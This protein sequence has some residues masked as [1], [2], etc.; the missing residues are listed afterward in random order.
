MKK[1]VFS[2]VM[3][4][5]LCLCCLLTSCNVNFGSSGRNSG[6]SK[7][8]VDQSSNNVNGGQNGGLGEEI[9]GD[10]WED[11]G[12]NRPG[13]SYPGYSYPGF[14]HPD[15]SYPSFSYPDFSYPDYS[16]PSFSYPDY[17]YPD[18]SE[19]EQ[20]NA[21]SGNNGSDDIPSTRVVIVYDTMYDDD[22]H[23]SVMVDR[24][25]TYDHHYIPERRGYS[26]Y[27]WYADKAM[28]VPANEDYRYTEDINF[29]YACWALETYSI[30]YENIDENDP[31]NPVSY[32]VWSAIELMA[33][34]ARE[35]YA[36][37]GWFLDEEL[38]EE[39]TVIENMVG[40][41]VLYAKW[42]EVAP[43]PNPPSGEETEPPVLT[44][45]SGMTL[46]I[47]AT[48]WVIDMGPSAPWAQVELTV[49]P[50]GWTDNSG[51]GFVI[52]NSVLRRAMDI[53]ENY[54][55]TLNWI[56]SRSNQIATLLAES[57][58][59]GNQNTSFHIAMP[60]MLELQRI[61]ST[62]SIYDLG[63]SRHIDL[64]KSY[65]NQAAREAYTV[66]DHT[67]F[68]AGDFSFLDEMTSRVIYYN[69]A[70]AEQIPAFPDIYQ[71]VREGEWTIDEMSNLSKLV[72]E[73]TGDESWGDE[74]VY[75][76]GAA[77][78]THL[79][80]TSG[81]RQVGI[82][83]FENGAQYT[84]TLNHPNISKLI[85]KLL[86]ISKSEWA[87][88]DWMGGYGAL[89][90]AFEEGRLLFYD[91]VLQK[92]DYFRS[93][94]E[95]FRVGVLPV[96]KLD[97]SQE[98]YCTPCSYQSVFMCIPKATDDREMSEY[99]VEILSYTGQKYIMQAYKENLKISFDPERAVESME[100]IENYIFP[101]IVYDVGKTS[102]WSGLLNDVEYEAYSQGKNNFT[103]AYSQ[104]FEEAQIVLSEWNFA[105]FDYM[106]D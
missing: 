48:V 94:T 18:Y 11:D 98:E 71:R 51:F 80:Q 52:N 100:M 93:Q 12:G 20:S 26:F 9:G 42:E 61:V 90:E 105:W 14:S 44:K 39:I 7:Y 97:D 104:A 15:Y 103:S 87:R 72:S 37:V 67:L 3:A 56:N 89:Q 22:E 50:D 55:V 1:R 64:G 32:D 23:R 84:V 77:S 38:T 83:E 70:M 101:N 40:A 8:S 62:N 19:S 5:L 53:K 41:L 4:L 28:T 82:K 69:T 10:G 63:A 21:S 27:G 91:E 99:F 30:E 58:V 59:A 49:S 78:L 36:F 16:Y 81:I 66:Y 33:P 76:Y 6:G 29:L 45:W 24:G 88:M 47:L 73:N 92:A 74:D 34:S 86:T 2:S 43:T 65:Y 31:S 79:Y 13:F 102:G 25:S 35:G 60:R 17:S 46:N 75:G 54:G 57:V 95:D 85:D 106:E 96:P 68:V